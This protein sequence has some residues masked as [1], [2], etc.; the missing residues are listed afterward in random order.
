MN[1]EKGLGSM[2]EL[3]AQLRTVLP[4]LTRLI[5]LL[6]KGLLHAPDLSELRGGVKQAEQASRDAAGRL[7]Q[8]EAT[9]EAQRAES[10]EAATAGRKQINQ[11]E[12][13]VAALGSRLRLLTVLAALE[14][15]LLIVL[16]VLRFR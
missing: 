14:L 9:I 16:I 3:L 1:V 11:L 5:P 4:Y 7:D 12:A 2:W 6:D 10:A 15:A 8:I 13:S